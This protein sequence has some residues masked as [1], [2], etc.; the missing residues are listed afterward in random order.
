MKICIFSRSINKKGNTGC[1]EFDQ[2]RALK[3]RGHR[4]YVLALDFRSFRR[5]RRPG[6]Y[7]DTIDGIPVVHCSVPMGPVKSKAG[8][9][10]ENMA[11]KR[12]YLKVEKMAGGFD[13]VNSHF[14]SIS[15]PCIYVII[16]NLKRDIP[17]IVTEHSSLMNVDRDEI[18]D[19][20]LMRAEYVY[21]RADGVIAVSSALA[22]R[23]KENFGVDSDVV[24]NVLDADDFKGGSSRPE[25][26]KKGFTFISAGN[27]TA[28]KRMDLLIS[29]FSRAFPEEVTTRLYIFGDGS[30]R[31]RLERLVEELGMEERIFLPGRKSRKELGDFYRRGDAFALTS[32]RETF[33]VAY[34]E[35]MACGMPVLACRSGGPEDF[36]TPE[37]GLIVDDD[38]DSVVEG[39]KKLKEGRARYDRA[40]ISEYAERICGEEA[41]SRRLTDIYERYLRKKEL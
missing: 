16:N 18:S 10:L 38:E 28:N 15:F 11:V 5:R 23:L 25:E 33:G 37:T 7:E 21:S 6:I 31:R 12:A 27:F 17:V 35:A 34:V 22:G 32:A 1:F 4:V 41:I 36:V 19:F 24:F 9:S 8:L 2:A 13:I 40:F 20:N 14:F 39:L 29:S 30:E 3:K 26:E